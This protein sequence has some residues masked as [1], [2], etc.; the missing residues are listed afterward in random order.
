MNKFEWGPF[1][2]AP[3]RGRGSGHG[4][5]GGRSSGVGRGDMNRRG[6]GRSGRGMDGGF[7]ERACRWNYELAKNPSD[8]EGMDLDGSG[9]DGDK[10]N[11]GTSMVLRYIQ[12]K[13]NFV[14]QK[15]S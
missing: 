4:A 13:S 6:G 7:G 11:D 1:I 8:L 3:R 14:G 2:L 15:A 5:S 12:K 9:K 10:L